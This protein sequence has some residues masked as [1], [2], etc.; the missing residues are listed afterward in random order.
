[1][2]ITKDAPSSARTLTRRQAIYLG[3]LAAPIVAGV[4]LSA[5]SASAAAGSAPTIELIDAVSQSVDSGTDR[6][7]GPEYV[8]Y[9]DLY[10][11]G[12]SLQAVVNRVT[13][14]RILTLPEGTFTF[15]DFTEGYYDG[16]RIGTGKAAGCRGIVGS[17]RNTIIRGVANT[18]S[19]DK[20]GS[21]AGNQITIA[22][23]PN[24]VLANFSVLGNP[25]NGLYFTGI[26]VYKCP[27]AN[28]SNLYLRG[29]SRGYSNSPPGETFG[30]NIFNSDR[31]TISDC[32]VDGRDDDGVP[33]GASPIGWNSCSD[34]KVYRT[35]CHDGKAGMLT[36]WETTN[37]YTED[38]KCFNT[39][40]GSGQL[41]GHGINHE[42][43]R[44]TITHVRPNLRLNGR[45][46]QSPTANAN[47]GIHMTLCNVDTDVPA[48][49]VIEPVYDHGPSKT[50]MFCIAAYN[51]YTI[52]GRTNQ[53]KST[54]KVTRN[55]ATLKAS[56]HPDAGWGDKD[57]SQY[58]GVIH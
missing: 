7:A 45:Y 28:V 54:P 26:V 15:R 46:S 24:A 32:E 47:S 8:R 53:C 16:I 49:T 19:R 6:P 51:G 9:E 37:V 2:T 55:G 34:A 52:Y 35:Y 41:S 36:F 30:I 22:S 21:I 18:A 3:V 44:G 57:S 4:S 12:D 38:Y 42:Q 23:Q 11:K 14:R 5:G 20:G 43:S 29:A 33:V 25:Q 50:D 13:N 31:A 39:A 10:V 40:S 27:D 58:F 1:M 17:G 56:N 48:F